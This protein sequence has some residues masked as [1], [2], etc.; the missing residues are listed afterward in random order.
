MGNLPEYEP[1]SLIALGYTPLARWQKASGSDLY[2]KVQPTRIQDA[3]QFKK[4]E[5]ESHQ[6]LFEIEDGESGQIIR[7]EDQPYIKSHLDRLI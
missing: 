4:L 5:G 3:A 6:I 7:I 1:Y 2:Q